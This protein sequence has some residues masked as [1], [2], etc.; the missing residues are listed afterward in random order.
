M[1]AQQAVG[2]LGR[3][4]AIEAA[5]S[6]G[7]R[8]HGIEARLERERLGDLE[9]YSLLVVSEDLAPYP[10]SARQDL[11]WRVLKESLPAEDLLSIVTIYTFTPREM[12]GDFE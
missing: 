2:V 8:R 6:E 3:I 11:A 10:F 9:K 5:L 1:A 4:D 12:N 7:L